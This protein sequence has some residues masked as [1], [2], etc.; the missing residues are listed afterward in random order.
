MNKAT[1]AN[2]ATAPEPTTVTLFKPAALLSGAPA[3]ASV[4]VVEIDGGSAPEGD[5]VGV[6]VGGAGGD[7]KGESE[8]GEAVGGEIGATIGGGDDIGGVNGGDIGDGAGA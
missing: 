7:D 1:A 4:G 2:K 5:I 8:G 3:G 6:E